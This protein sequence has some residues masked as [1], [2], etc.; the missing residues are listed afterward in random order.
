MNKIGRKQSEETKIKIRLSKLGKKR[1]PF[2]EE[3]KENIRKARVASTY[4]HSKETKLK[5][6]QNSKWKNRNV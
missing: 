6:S 3:W 2:S 1:K 5:M 4:K